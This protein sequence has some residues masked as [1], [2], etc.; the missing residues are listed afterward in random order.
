MSELHPQRPAAVRRQRSWGPC[1][2]LVRDDG[3]RFDYHIRAYVMPSPGEV[4]ATAERT[5]RRWIAAY[6]RGF[7]WE[8]TESPQRMMGA[9]RGQAALAEA[10]RI[11]LDDPTTSAAQRFLLT[12]RGPLMPHFQDASSLG[13]PRTHQREVCQSVGVDDWA[14]QKG[15]GDQKMR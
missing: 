14:L 4:A 1:F 7:H 8:P 6:R 3:A 10:K 11:I 12:L 13:L 15:Q 5:V 9:L 2:V